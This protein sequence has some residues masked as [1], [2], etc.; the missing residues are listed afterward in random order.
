MESFTLA[1]FCVPSDSLRHV[2]QRFV[3]AHISSCCT[4]IWVNLLPLLG[5][6]FSFSHLYCSSVVTPPHPLICL[7]FFPSLLLLCCIFSKWTF[8]FVSTGSYIYFL[9]WIFLL[10]TISKQ[11]KSNLL[12]KYEWRHR[13]SD[14]SPFAYCQKDLASWLILSAVRAF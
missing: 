13:F 10:D 1:L 4:Q 12:F 5:T 8:I 7:S 9:I 2:F 3:P 6:H 14:F 11:D